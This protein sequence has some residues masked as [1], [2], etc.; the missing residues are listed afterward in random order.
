[1]QLLLKCMTPKDMIASANR[2]AINAALATPARYSFPAMF[3][4]LTIFRFTVL[5]LQLLRDVFAVD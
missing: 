1:M 5:V 3:V 4:V 2:P